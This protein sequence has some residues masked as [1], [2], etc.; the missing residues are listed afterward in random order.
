MTAYN[1]ARVGI[2][3]AAHCV[4]VGVHFGQEEQREFRVYLAQGTYPGDER[5]RA[6]GVSEG[7]SPVEGN[8]VEVG[9]NGHQ[10]AQPCH[11]EAAQQTGALN[12]VQHAPLFRIIGRA[13]VVE[14]SDV[15]G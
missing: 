1:N 7:V 3:N 14:V 6:Q 12:V 15:V 8:R 13:T 9:R 4:N 10:Q 2:G 11:A 5:C